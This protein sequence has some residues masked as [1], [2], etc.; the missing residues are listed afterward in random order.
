MD[1]PMARNLTVDEILSDI[2]QEVFKNEKMI[3]L[4]VAL[5]YMIQLV[6]PKYRE[7]FREAE[8]KAKTVDDMTKILDLVKKH[9]GQK[10]AINMLGI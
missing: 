5:E 2:E 10:T 7:I 6:E 3:K 9:I 8:L 4:S 1:E